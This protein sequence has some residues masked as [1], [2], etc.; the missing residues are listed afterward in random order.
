MRAKEEK[1][2]FETTSKKFELGKRKMDN[3]CLLLASE[4]TQYLMKQD[5]D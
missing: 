1:G 4:Q 3:V 2:V 5:L